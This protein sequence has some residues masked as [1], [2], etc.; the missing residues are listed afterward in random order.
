LGCVAAIVAYILGKP[1]LAL[2]LCVPVATVVFGSASTPGLR[3]AGRYGDISFGLYIYA[4]PAQQVI[5]WYFKDHLPWSVGL[6]LT[7]VT[8]SMLAF[9][10]W[11]AVEKW[12][13]SLKP[14][15]TKTRP[16]SPALQ[17]V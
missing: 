8:T 16:S 11:H 7:I 3:Q 17:S 14:K 1:L 10:S 12:A 6:G 2:W 15:T 4:F 13:L 9:L 5:I